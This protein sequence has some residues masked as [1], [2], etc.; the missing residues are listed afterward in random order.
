MSI[1]YICYRSFK[2]ILYTIDAIYT[3]YIASKFLYNTVPMLDRDPISNIIILYRLS[4]KGSV[5]T[6]AR[7]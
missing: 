3:D 1:L 2:S 5:E 4:K 6:I 7:L